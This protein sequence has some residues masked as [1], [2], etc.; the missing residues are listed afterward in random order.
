[1]D[2]SIPSTKPDAT[3][4]TNL[5]AY[6]SGASHGGFGG[7]GEAD[8]AAGSW[9]GFHQFADGFDEFLDVGIVAFNAAFQFRELGQHLPV[10]GQGF[11]HA[12]EGADNE[13]A[14]FNGTSGVQDRRGHDGAVFG[15]GVG[16]G[17]PPTM[18]M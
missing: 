15:K 4:A 10:G 14:H 1:M 16:K 5:L 8:A 17:S 18:S 3:S 13:D 7:K 6:A 2:Q 11:A 12:H 9:Q